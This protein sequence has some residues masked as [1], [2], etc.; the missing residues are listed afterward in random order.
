MHPVYG[1]CAPTAP[2]AATPPRTT[3][4]RISAASRETRQ[5]QAVELPVQTP[6][7]GL[8]RDRRPPD[9]RDETA[10]P[11]RVLPADPVARRR[12]EV[13]LAAVG[14]RRQDPALAVD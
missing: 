6:A 10:Q 4:S 5:H 11:R 14:V 12:P 9:L 8:Q 2:C 1:S 3:S 13:R 7:A